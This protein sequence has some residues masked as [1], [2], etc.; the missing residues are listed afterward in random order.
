ME[1][2]QNLLCPLRRE[3]ALDVGDHEDQESKQHHDLDHVINKELNAA[4]PTGCN[5]YTESVQCIANNFIEPFHAKNLI[6]DEQPDRAK[7]FHSK[8][9]FILIYSKISKYS[10]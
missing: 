8:S 1:S 6:L 7:D 3:I 4:A 5:I 2:A 10:F 9:P